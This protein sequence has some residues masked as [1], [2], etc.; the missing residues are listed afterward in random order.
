MGDHQGSSAPERG[1]LSLVLNCVP[2][3]SPFLS[4]AHPLN[5]YASECFLSAPVVL[6]N[7]AVLRQPRVRVVCSLLLGD[8]GPDL[9]AG[10]GF[11]AGTV[12]EGCWVGL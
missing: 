9:P 4:S 1:S 10:S 12:G 8:G 6:M 5:L 7:A 11:W 2:R 3:C